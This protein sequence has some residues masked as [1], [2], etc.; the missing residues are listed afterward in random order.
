MT[1][2]QQ[3]PAP[4]EQELLRQVAGIIRRVEDSLL[5]SFSGSMSTA[6]SLSGR[7]ESTISVGSTETTVPPAH[8]VTPSLPVS[9]AHGPSDLI[10][11]PSPHVFDLGDHDSSMGLPHQTPEQEQFIHNQLQQSAPELLPSEWFDLSV[12]PN[13]NVCNWPFIG[14]TTPAWTQ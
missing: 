3:V 2:A 12:D 14:F 4:I 7:R 10:P 9:T 11:A 13:D 1:S 6:P 8:S 5:D